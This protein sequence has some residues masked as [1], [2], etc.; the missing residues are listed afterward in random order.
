MAAVINCRMQAQGRHQNYPSQGL[1]MNGPLSPSFCSSSTEGNK[2]GST[3]HYMVVCSMELY[4]VLGL[5]RYK[6]ESEDG[7]KPKKM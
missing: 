5:R 6:C 7:R 1:T 3:G 4:K 2:L